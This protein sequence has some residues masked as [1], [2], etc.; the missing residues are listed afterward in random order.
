MTRYCIVGAGAIGSTIGGYLSR[1]GEDIT[2]IDTWAD[3]VNTMVS[4]G[5][6][7]TAVEEQF[8]T[9]IKALHLGNANTIKEKFDVIFISV[10][11]YDTIWATHFALN[12]LRPEGFLVS[13]QNG[14]N[15]DIIGNISGFGRIVGCVVTLGAGLYNP[16]NVEHTSVGNRLAF[17]IGEPHGIITTRAKNLAKALEA[18][19]TTNTTTN[20][21]GQRWAKL[22]V[23][24]M[25]NPMCALTGITSSESRSNP[26]VADKGIRIGR[27]VVMTAKQLG[28]QVEAINNIP[29][30]SYERSTHPEVLEEIK[31]ELAAGAGGSGAGLPSMLQDVKKNRRTEIEY[32]NGYTSIKAQEVGVETPLCNSITELIRKVER[33]ELDPDINNLKLLDGPR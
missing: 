20:L 4:N 23:N 14:I 28:I 29:A 27:E 9:P 26:E 11:S 7:V 17:T 32:L 5:L 22:A 12:Y 24:C 25:A 21:W 8:T 6:T 2:L 18:V 16:G 33:K 3:H 31:S 30:D 19:G 1:A 15:D 13:A 10:K